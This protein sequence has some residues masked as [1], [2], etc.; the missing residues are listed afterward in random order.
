MSIDCCKS[1]IGKQIIGLLPTDGGSPPPPDCWYYAEVKGFNPF[2]IY[3]VDQFDLYYLDTNGTQQAFFLPGNGQNGEG[4]LQNLMNA[5][6]GNV[7]GVWHP[8]S[9]EWIYTVYYYG[10]DIF[11]P[12]L[13]LYD[14]NG[15]LANTIQF[16]KIDM[17]GGDCQLLVNYSVNIPYG[18]E[19]AYQYT[20]N[21]T[22]LTWFFDYNYS[23]QIYPVG[24]TSLDL[25]DAIIMQNFVERVYGPQAIYKIIDNGSSYD[26][27]INDAIYWGDLPS[28][29]TISGTFNF[30][31]V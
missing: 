31:Q 28:V 8:A 19:L 2:G 23:N 3:P 17:I 10:Q 16:N 27:S 24:A 12:Y 11:A 1:Y 21:F 4:E 7:A 22:S 5:N 20:V 26:I 9:A 6:L 15:N 30:I 25:S 14:I 29:I 18:N 13:P